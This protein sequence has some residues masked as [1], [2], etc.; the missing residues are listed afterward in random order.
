M[1]SGKCII[2]A[3]KQ[4]G[5][6]LFFALSLINGVYAAE[7]CTVTVIRKDNNRPLIDAIVKVV[8]LS[9]PTKG[10]INAGLTNSSG[11]YFFSITEPSVVLIS[12][13]GFVSI[14]D[15]FTVAQDKVYYTGP[16]AQEIND[17]V[18]TGQYAPNSVQKS[19]YEVKVINAETIKSKGANN[20][21]EAL[22]NELSIDLGQ[23]QV[24]GSSLGINGISGEGIKIMVDGVP[25]VGRLDGKLDLSQININN[26]ERIEIVEGP[27]SVMYGT[28]AMGGVINIITKSFQPEKINLQLR[29]YY[30][31][32]GQYNVDLN[33]GFSFRKS[34]IFLS[35]GRYFFD[36]FTTYDSIPRFM[37]W[38]PKE[39]YFTDAKY[40]YSGNKFRFSLTGAFFR[41][42]MVNRSA[43]KQTL[44]Y[45]NNDTAWTYTG[46]DIKY[47]TYRPRASASLMYRFNENSQLDV[48][49]AY[50]GFFRFTNKY[51]KNLVT[52]KETLVNDP[53]DQDTARYHQLLIRST[54]SLPAWKNK[55]NFQFGI[56]V[57]QEYT[58]QTRIKDGKQSSGDYAAYGSVRYS[59]VKGLDVQPAVR[60][61]YN[62]RFRAPLV[63]SINIKY[64]W[65]DQLVFRASYGKGYRAPSLK[66]LYLVFF[67][68]NHS[69]QG[70]PNLIAEN[71]HI[72]NGTFNYTQTVKK[73]SIT[74]GISGFYNNINNKIDWR[75]IPSIGPEL[76]TF[77]YINIKRYITYGGDIS[78]NY[79]WNRF[80][81]NTSAMLTSYRL[82]N[83]VSGN[84]R[85]TTW[86]PDFTASTSYKIPV[87]EINV[88]VFYKFNG[89]KPLFSI[90]NSLQTGFRD[91]YHTLDI[92]FNRNF[93][94]DRIQLIIGGKN[95]VGVSNVGAQNVSSIGHNFGGNAVNI[96]WGRTFFSSLVFRFAK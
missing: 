76:D 43:P 82:S 67:D 51:D 26:I 72:V 48:L 35:G 8:P 73:H 20:L 39:Q 85:I 18:V 57:N 89:R 38:K 87:A 88:T 11:Q 14:T 28:D 19:V 75:I 69:L 27:L 78:L 31:T 3:I 46:A 70:N 90:N 41:E 45:D 94:K 44:S 33:A 50:S 37:E 62:T 92:S 52:L 24:F 80:Q 54:Y 16:V 68:S 64:N 7:N 96:G 81:M 17:V 93:W 60:I 10:K 58:T 5:V 13:L 61:I 21:R 32:V 53:R 86:S 63:P 23:D 77:E 59:V 25:I 83:T 49:L 22:Q 34:Q 42:L 36:G 2:K 55:L 29:G 1:S 40:M 12:Y 84:D 95:L 56:E 15:T 65:K 91:A 74:Y 4:L 47:L 30:E 66:E 6:N 71:G 79:K 9:N